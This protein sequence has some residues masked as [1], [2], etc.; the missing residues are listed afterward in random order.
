[1]TVNSAT[2]AGRLSQPL[3]LRRRD[4]GACKAGFRPEAR[5]TSGSAGFRR[6]PA[7][8]TA[9][10]TTVA[11]ILR[12]VF[13]IALALALSGPAPAKSDDFLG[14]LYKGIKRSVDRGHRSNDR[15]ILHAVRRIVTFGKPGDRTRWKNSRTGT[16]GMVT[17][18]S[19]SRGGSGKTCWAYSRTEVAGG[20][21][22]KFTGRAC[23]SSGFR[24]NRA[25][26]FWKIAD[27]REV[28]RAAGS[29]PVPAKGAKDVR[30]AQSML[31]GLGYDAGP[32][33][34][35]MGSRTRNA[36]LA[37]QRD[38]DL[39]R[40]GQV[41]VYLLHHLK[42]VAAA[43]KARSPMPPAAA[44]RT[45]PLRDR[46]ASDPP[47]TRPPGQGETAARTGRVSRF[48]TR[49]P[50]VWKTIWSAT[51]LA[52]WQKEAAED[53]IELA[54]DLAADSAF[55]EFFLA[56]L[57]LTTGVLVETIKREPLKMVGSVT[58]SVGVSVAKSVATSLAANI[59]ADAILQAKTFNG[60]DSSTK[61]VLHGLIVGSVSVAI[62]TVDDFR[63]GGLQAA[64]VKGA[65]RRIVDIVEIYF[66]TAA[67]VAVQ[68]RAFLAVAVSVD[69]S[70]DLETTVGTNRARKIAEAVY[71]NSRTLVPD[72]YGKDDKKSVQKI[73]DTARQALR[74]QARNEP[75]AARKLAEQL[76]K[77]GRVESNIRPWTALTNFKDY[78]TAAL[79]LGKDAPER[80]AEILVRATRL[81]ELFEDAAAKKR[82]QAISG[83]ERFRKV[84][85]RDPSPTASDENGWTDL[86]YA[87]ALNL[88]ELVEVL[89]R[90]GAGVA[91]PIKSDR[92]PISD[93]L[94]RTLKRL[95]LQFDSSIPGKE[96]IPIERFGQQPL[97]LATI[98]NARESLTKL[99]ELGA[100][101]N[102]KDGVGLTALHYAVLV[103]DGAKVGTELI[104][105]GAD[106]HAKDHGT[107]LLHFAARFGAAKVA[108]ELIARG[109]DI[110]AKDRKGMTPLHY[111]V[112]NGAEKLAME[113]I[114]RGAD[115]HAKDREG[116]TLLHYAAE[117]HPALRDAAAQR[118]R[119]EKL[120]MEL[121]A[122]GADIHA[123]DRKG[124]TPLHYAARHGAEKLA[125]ELIARGA[126]IHA[127]DRRGNTPL[128]HSTALHPVREGAQRLRAAKLAMELIARGADIHAKNR[129]GETPLDDAKGNLRRDMLW[130][131]MEREATASASDLSKDEARTLEQ[132]SPTC[133]GTDRKHPSSDA[134]G[135]AKRPLPEF[136]GVY[137]RMEDGS[138]VELKYFHKKSSTVK[139][140]TYYTTRGGKTKKRRYPI[141]SG[142]YSNFSESYNFKPM[143]FSADNFTNI[144]IV[145]ENQIQSMMVNGR[146]TTLSF[147]K[148]F[149]LFTQYFSDTPNRFSFRSWC[150]RAESR[151]SK[152]TSQ[153]F[154]DDKPLS[155][156]HFFVNAG[157]GTRA[158][159]FRV[160]NHDAFNTEYVPQP[161][162]VWNR[163]VFRNHLGK[164]KIPVIFHGIN[165]KKRIYGT[166]Y[167]E[168]HFIFSTIQNIR[169]L[170]ANRPA[171]GKY[172]EY[173][174]KRGRLV[175]LESVIETVKKKGWI[176]SIADEC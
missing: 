91:T 171:Y 97:H 35:L 7:A 60:M 111:A 51:D 42:K 5:R 134:S 54:I 154:V 143:I 109:A 63:T 112:E 169:R 86:H 8:A 17:L 69:A 124:M 138:F 173:Q 108:M 76:R 1:M 104:A 22:K 26:A 101:V 159:A 131:A 98:Y 74:L 65:A 31:N 167:N 40:T 13:P 129:S 121:I 148:Y 73:L 147:W 96:V 25:V 70:V 27:E 77:M 88:P 81:S 103:R 170:I 165:L 92:R 52:T 62:Q 32:A 19:R 2:P 18:L 67:A 90:S 115:I 23:R 150:T 99:L 38:N 161:G 151:F 120:A 20:T 9:A 123:K 4:P 118:L 11:G 163:K 78:F 28:G 48:K 137:L 39:P 56:N 141:F 59:V 162:D 50:G 130:R 3:P 107:T 174:R 119:A 24:N 72:I 15:Y 87:A 12:F 127:K 47:A 66:A 10:T 157:W 33:D 114:A 57:Q 149:S 144:P 153:I 37:F 156:E 126:D 93:S 68:D 95:K 64:V 100:N 58:G 128:H 16:R 113:L 80:A 21:V 145:D 155:M 136:E 135:N 79:R 176:S 125:M 53:G 82:P 117:L 44:N 34:G 46:E 132:P 175:D 166:R 36:I 14:K 83:A 116:M 61:A 110:H 41:E 85:G 152:P 6:G 105:R 164:R 158:T 122:R 94:K 89:V 140:Q 55:K 29:K 49:F 75:D 84:L 168:H 43:R 102:A 146:N 172:Q 45:G 106:I 142:G 139:C 30:Q 160:R 71:R 133:K